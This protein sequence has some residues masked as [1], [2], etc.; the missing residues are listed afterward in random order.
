MPI[1]SNPQF[2]RIAVPVGSAKVILV[3]RAFTTDEYAKFMSG[4]Y[5]FKKKGRLE[6]KS[7]NARIDFIDAL[8]VDIEALDADDNPDI[9]S[10]EADGKTQTLTPRVESWKAYVNPSWKIS[11]ALELEGVAAEEMDGA[12]KK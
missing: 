2:R 11:A 7:M 9:I 3:L 10:Y 12:L 5:S 1:V 4:R 6:D 8:L